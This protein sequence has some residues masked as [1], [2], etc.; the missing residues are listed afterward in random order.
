MSFNF[1]TSASTDRAKI[2]IHEQRAFI[3]NKMAR[4]LY[5]LNH[6]YCRQHYEESR[7]GS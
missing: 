7:G 6:S 1:L 2:T 4:R 3:W 5:L